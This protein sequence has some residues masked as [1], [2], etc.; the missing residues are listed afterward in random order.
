MPSTDELKAHATSSVDFYALLSIS[1]SATEPEIGS[2]F[3]K[4]SLKYHPDKVG[5]TQAN[6]D[7]FLLVKIAHDVLSDPIIRALYDQTREAKVR[8]EA[9]TEKLDAGRRK[10][11]S[12]LERKERHAQNMGGIGIMGVKR[13]RFG[14]ED[15]PKQE[16]EREIRRIS[17][18]NRR[19]KKAMMERSERERREEEER[20]F[21]EKEARERLEKAKD[22][23]GLKRQKQSQSFSFPR[24]MDQTSTT[25][26]DQSQQNGLVF[27]KTILERLKTA[28]TL[29]MMR[30][31]KE[32]EKE[33]EKQLQTER[34]AEPDQGT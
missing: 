25:L 26:E 18:E 34:V 11:V 23:D 31:E 8:R 17:E 32:R 1:P 13:K 5:S 24:K 12:E 2:A 28:Q 27:E 29:K 20:L 33:Q 30:R 9:E 22:R 15:S 6:V 14:E 4:T 16:L 10:M 19:K 3:R 21:D 7:K